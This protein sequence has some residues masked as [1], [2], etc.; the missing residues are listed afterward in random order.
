MGEYFSGFRS[1]DSGYP[2]GSRFWEGGQGSAGAQSYFVSWSGSWL[3]G[4]ICF[5]KS[6][7]ALHLWFY[8]YL[9]GYY[10]LTKFEFKESVGLR[11]GTGVR[12]VGHLAL[13]GVRG[14]VT[15]NS[16]AGHWLRAL[17][18]EPERSRFEPVWWLLARYAA[19]RAIDE[20][21]ERVSGQTM[22][23]PVKSR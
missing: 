14:L 21:R 11:L 6:N 10:T 12:P 15:Y 22:K 23:D 20:G 9:Y 19:G 5:V 7:Q 18:W 2:W 13:T 3:H 4:Y 8:T 1:Q 16:T 17:D